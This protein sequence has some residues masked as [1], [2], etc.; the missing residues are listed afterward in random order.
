[1]WA[2]FCGTFARVRPVIGA[3]ACAGLLVSGCVSATLTDARLTGLGRRA[4]PLSGQSQ[5]QQV[6]DAS[7]CREHVMDALFYVGGYTL[8]NP[9]VSLSAEQAIRRREA[10]LA[11]CLRDLGYAIAEP[12]SAPSR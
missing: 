6:M 4:L 9:L 5:R 10:D 2:R 7:D 12:R 1:M 3:I 11:R 8:Y